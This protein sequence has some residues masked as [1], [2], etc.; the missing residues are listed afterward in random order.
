MSCSQNTITPRRPIGTDY[1]LDHIYLLY[2]R[3]SQIRGAHIYTTQR[4]VRPAYMHQVVAGL[5]HLVF[6]VPAI[7]PT[8]DEGLNRVVRD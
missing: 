7:T 3:A 8:V 2:T 5:N 6:S 1:R 4:R